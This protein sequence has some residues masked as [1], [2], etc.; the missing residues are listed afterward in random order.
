MTL[1]F[2]ENFPLNIHKIESFNST[3]PSEL[4]QQRLIKVL[5]EINRKEFSFEEAANPTIPEC[6]IIF[7]FG[8]ADSES[9]NYIDEEEVRKVQNLPEKEYLRTM[10]FFCVIRY[11][12]G[13]KKSALKFDYYFIRTVYG[14]NILEIQVSH[15]KGP[16][17]LSPEDL[18]LLI[19]NKTNEAA[20]RKILKR[21]PSSTI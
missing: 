7:E 18:V 8:L 15:K 5:Y 3:L 4:L 12:K 14:K 19:V 1:G 9:F 11:Y 16:R 17:H 6:K 2:Y 21:K 13:E 10:D 20:N